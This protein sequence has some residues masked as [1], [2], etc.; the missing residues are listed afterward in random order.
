MSGFVPCYD[1][2]G[3][4]LFQ[5]SMDAGDRWMLNDATGKPMLA[6]DDRNHQFRT[7]YD[8]LHRPTGSF[9]KGA[10]S[11]NANRTIQFEKVVYG[12]TPSNGLSDAAK[13]QLN[14][15]GKPYQQFDTAGVVVSKGRNP[16]TGEE[17]G[18][19]FKGNLLRSTRQ[20]IQDYKKT[21]DWSQATVLETEVF[22]SST[23]YDALNRPV[24]MVAPHSNKPGSKLNVIRPGYNEANL[25]E[26]VDLWGGQAN[27]PIALLSPNTATDKIVKNINHDAKGQRI[28]IDYGNNSSTAYTY[29]TQTFRLLR[30][31]T[32]RTGAFAASTLLLVNSGTLQ[33]LNYVYDPVGNIT[34][35][36]DAALPV[37]SY[38]GEQV[39]PVSRYTYDA[40]YRLIEA[41]GRE[42]AGQTNYQPIAPRD[43]DRDY[44][45]QNLPNAN[46]MQALRNYTERYDYDAVGNILGMIHSVQNGGWNRAYDYESSNNRL[47][48]T[49]LPGD[50]A[51]TYSAKYGYDEH[52]NMTRM[53]HLPL[54]QWDFKDQLQAASQQV[55]NGGTPEITYFVYDAS[56]ERVR[57]VTER[58]N[59]TLK[60]ERIYLGGFEIYREYNGDGT[61]VTL[62]RETL[63]VMDD[64]RRVALVET[65]TLEIKDGLGGR[66]ENQVAVV[67]YQ[68]D[69]HLGSAS[70]ELD[71]AGNVISY[72][73][74]HP[75]GTTSYQA[76]NS[77]AE[78]SLKRY[79][80]TG[81]E[82]DEETGLYYHGA[83]YYAA[84]LGRW[85]T[86]DPIGIGD[87]LNLYVYVH[88][89]PVS[90]NDP[91]GN[92]GVQSDADKI[93]EREWQQNIYKNR[94][95]APSSAGKGSTLS[96]GGKGSSGKLPGATP[97]TSSP[98][99][100]QGNA[101]RSQLGKKTGDPNGTNLTG[102]GMSKA[103][104]T[105]TN[106][107]GGQGKLT[108]QTTA[109]NETDYATLLGS[110]FDA[111]FIDTI[112][113][114]AFGKSQEQKMSGGV[115]L[116]HGNPANVSEAGQGAYLAVN[117]IFAFLGEI[118][119]V[120]KAALREFKTAQLRAAILNEIKSG[121]LTT[122]SI[123]DL[124]HNPVPLKPNEIA[125]VTAGVE[126]L[127][128]THS[129]AQ[130]GTAAHEAAGANQHSYAHLFGETPNAGPDFITH[131]GAFQEELKTHFGAM[132][133]SHIDSA[134][135]QSLADSIKYQQRTGLV[136]IRSVT[137]IYINPSTGAAVKFRTH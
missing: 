36:R 85:V 40:L 90:L 69:N 137:H 24:Q 95:H 131:Q 67:R 116:G 82:R 84:W 64:Q 33:D 57:K 32:T 135:A 92:K 46:D 83:R 133:Q 54:M 102:T 43:N 86:C 8:E 59:G 118:K 37:I 13:L 117:L 68:L 93:K 105:T 2:A 11:L 81:K 120:G 79:R 115:Q 71:K 41:R 3:N 96:P 27:E 123:N 9:V 31:H 6:W 128:Q 122:Q 114:F 61:A 5:H 21:P 16:A 10:D 89:N 70:L 17:E 98:G 101:D 119:Q 91:N 107:V 45:F 50:A 130:A 19:D 127:H 106:L 4:L 29:D 47:R 126:N 129:P 63:H 94:L 136:P 42:H 56:G 55:R 44:P 7:E 132:E 58:Q 125:G 62:E 73:E 1:I 23:R 38:A 60:N 104:G 103:G 35:I 78:V 49:S 80:Y 39:E 124:F 88:S 75:Y 28:R 97:K 22:S 15:R 52:G 112:L 72:E 18:F 134:S 108:N 30:L 14:L 74:Y 12:D 20:L 76:K 111:P 113:D 109:K 66:I 100:P 77:G 121:Q 53:P 99:D 65:K 34:E 26:R 51:G 25:L 87:G 48:A 110:I